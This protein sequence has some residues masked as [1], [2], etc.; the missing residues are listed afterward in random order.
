MC[1][2]GVGRGEREDD[3]WARPSQKPR[4]DPAARPLAGAEV[5]MAVREPSPEEGG[6]EKP[7]WN[8]RKHET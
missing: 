5:L 2:Q 1:W 6:R 4:K 3:G 8:I 7:A